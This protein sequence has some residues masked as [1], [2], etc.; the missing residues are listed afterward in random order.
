MASVQHSVTSRTIAIGYLTDVRQ[1]ER[2]APD[3]DGNAMTFLA[4]RVTMHNG[5]DKEGKLRYRYVDVTVDP[6]LRAMFKPLVG[7]DKAALSDHRYEL[8][9]RNLS[10]EPWFDRKAK[11]EGV[12]DRG[13][14]V[15]CT[16][17]QDEG[18]DE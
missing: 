4:A 14:L 1:V 18:E 2:K 15:G 7:Q 8:T 3:A 9:I 10:S 6:A 17:V 12:N 13:T 5:K 16:V 11:R